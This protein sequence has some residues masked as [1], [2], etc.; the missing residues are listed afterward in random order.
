MLQNPLKWQLNGYG[1]ACEPP[2]VSREYFKLK[3]E[4]IVAA[5]YL[6]NTHEAA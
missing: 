3:K 5:H 2:H 1:I 6:L 4:S